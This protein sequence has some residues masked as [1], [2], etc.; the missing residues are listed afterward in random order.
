MKEQKIR[1]ILE[2]L[3]SKGCKHGLGVEDN[4]TEE[5][6]DQALSQISALDKIDEEKLAKILREYFGDNSAVWDLVAKA[7]IQRKSEWMK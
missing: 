7:I 1:K 3:Y 5:D 6:I 2:A 4:P